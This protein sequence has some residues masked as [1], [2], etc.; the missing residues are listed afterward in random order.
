[1]G[2]EPVRIVPAPMT[3]RLSRAKSL[4]V[5]D[6][7][8]LEEID[9]FWQ[10]LEANTGLTVQRLHTN[11]SKK[12]DYQWDERHIAKIRRRFAVDFRNFGYE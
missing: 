11:Q 3:A 1:M 4:M 8:K 10:A 2:V 7:F 12:R 6:V 5:D 9:R